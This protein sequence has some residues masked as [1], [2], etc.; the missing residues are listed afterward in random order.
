MP[1]CPVRS[2]GTLSESCYCAGDCSSGGRMPAMSPYA[3]LTASASASAKESSV[4]R[5]PSPRISSRR[6]SVDVPR[7]STNTCRSDAES[8]WN[9][10]AV[11]NAAGTA[12][13]VGDW[14]MGGFFY[15]RWI[16]IGGNM[17]GIEFG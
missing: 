5:T 17:Y 12:A 8:D 11:G 6:I 7:A 3:P 15:G 1:G 4:G 13:W 16:G 2:R 10:V 9:S 14:A